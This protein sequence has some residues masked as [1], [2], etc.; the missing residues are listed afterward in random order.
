MHQSESNSCGIAVG[1]QFLLEEDVFFKENGRIVHAGQR[2][3]I[4]EVIGAGIPGDAMIR[5]IKSEGVNADPPGVEFSKPLANLKRGRKISQPTPPVMKKGGHLEGYDA[6]GKKV[7]LDHAGKGGMSVGAKHTEDG[8]KGVVGTEERPIEFEGEEIILTAPV[9]SDPTK[10]EFEGKEM[11][12]REIASQLNVN[13]GGVSFADG[14]QASMSC[15]C[16][17]KTY[18]YGGRECS[19]K[20]ILHDLISKSELR[21]GIEVETA[22]HY[23]TL[24]KLNA[25]SITIQDAIKEIAQAHLKENPRYYSK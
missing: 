21:K 11:T 25:G 13:N 6:N 9:S 15:K 3:S 2:K 16:S 7:Q 14:G 12:A 17:G 18:K 24:A 10:Y 4:V 5:V 22:E 1:D 8:I 23:E 20:E 19:D